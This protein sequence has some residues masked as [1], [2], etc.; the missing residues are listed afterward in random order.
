[1]AGGS[2]DTQKGGNIPV[3]EETL[4]AGNIRSPVGTPPKSKCPPGYEGRLTCLSLIHHASPHSRHKPTK[5][6]LTTT[7]DTR[8]RPPQASSPMA[9]G[10]RGPAT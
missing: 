4:E 3:A 9:G 1:M 5:P 2:D 8:P 7:G 10:P 6:L